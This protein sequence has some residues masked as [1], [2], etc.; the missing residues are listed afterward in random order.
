MNEK[1]EIQ[2]FFD[3]IYTDQDTMFLPRKKD[4]ILQILNM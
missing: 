4:K 1:K 2:K 3:F